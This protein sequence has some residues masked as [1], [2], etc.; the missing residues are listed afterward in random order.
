MN[1]NQ[2]RQSAI[3]DFMQSLEQLNELWGS[4]TETT[5]LDDNPTVSKQVNH[6]E[7][8]SRP[9]SVDPLQRKPTQAEAEAQQ[10]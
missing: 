3:T 5:V 1:K 7:R 8:L 10:T 4:D 2:L 6:P 9:Y